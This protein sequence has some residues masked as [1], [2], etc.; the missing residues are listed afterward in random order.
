ML[1]FSNTNSTKTNSS[2]TRASRL[3][4]WQTDDP[5][6]RYRE[7]GEEEK[8][9]CFFVKYFAKFFWSKMF[10]NTKNF[11]M[12]GKDFKFDQILQ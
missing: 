5:A 7:R 1:K 4:V 11:A 10:Y 3:L 6:T 12:N 9:L 8:S 2:T